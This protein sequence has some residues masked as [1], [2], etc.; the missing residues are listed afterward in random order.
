MN[1]L[2]HMVKECIMDHVKSYI[3]MVLCN[4]CVENHSLRPLRFSPLNFEFKLF[5]LTL[6]FLTVCY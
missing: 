4:I 5:I 6:T 3:F 1:I 2:T